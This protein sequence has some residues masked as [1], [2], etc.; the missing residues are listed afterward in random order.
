M[1]Q[2]EA[3]AMA[4]G[5]TK[6]S[7]LSKLGSQVMLRRSQGRARPRPDRRPRWVKSGRARASCARGGSGTLEALKPGVDVAE[8]LVADSLGWERLH[9]TPRHA[10]LSHEGAKTH[11]DAGQSRIHP[12]LGVGTMAAGTTDRY[13]WAPRAGSGTIVAAGEGMVEVGDGSSVAVE[14]TVG[15]AW[16][17][18]S[19]SP[20]ATP[21]LDHPWTK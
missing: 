12:S 16:Q 17:A 11:P 4:V 15:P 19:R 6:T 13:S 5:K 21:T 10:H 20:S 1:G 7:C 14:G 3:M 2:K 18:T 9:L 8:L